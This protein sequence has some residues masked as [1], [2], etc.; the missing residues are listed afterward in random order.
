MK[1]IDQKINILPI[2]DTVSGAKAR[3]DPNATI[4]HYK[5]L[6]KQL[7]LPPKV[8]NIADD[9]LNRV[10][11]GNTTWGSISGPY[12]FGKTANAI[13][14]WEYARRQ[15]YVVIPPLTC[16]S[17]DELAYGIAALTEV[18]VPKAKKQVRTLFK[19]IWKEELKQI[20]QKD[21]QRY[22]ISVEKITRI[23]EDKLSDGHLTIDGHCH[24]LVEFLSKLGE[25][26]LDYSKGLIII[27]D[28][29]QQLLGPLDVRSIV[30]F[31]E[32]VWG[33]RTERSHCG[34]VLVFDSLL[35]A[36]LERWA[37][38]VL[39][40]IRENGPSLQLSSVYSQ[41]FPFWLWEK[42]IK[43][44][45][46]QINPLSITGD[47]LKSLG[48]FVERSDI[49][50]GPRTVVDVFSRAIGFYAET[51][52]S[53]DIPKFVQDINT[54]QFRYFGE[55]ALIQR[56]LNQL[57]S[58]E[59][60][61][62][63]ETRK[64]LVTTL[65][66]YPL[67]CPQTIISR[68]IPDNT[69]FQRARSDLFGALLVE[70]SNG[71]ALEQFQHVRRPSANWE[72][73]LSRCWETLP[74]FDAL[75]AHLPDI[76]SRIL[77]SRIFPKGNPNNPTWERISDDSRYLLNG[78]QIYRGSFDDSYPSREVA[79]SVSYSG[80][81]TWLND[82]DICI[83]F[84]CNSEIQEPSAQLIEGRRNCIVLNMPILKS[85][86]QYV[87]AELERYKKFIQPE[88]FRPASILTAMHEIEIF[89][90]A[91][92]GQSNEIAR[93]TENE[94]WVRR[95][96]ALMEISLDFVVREM[97]QGTVDV[98][99]N[100]LLNL[101]GIELIRALFTKSCREQF[102]EYITLIKSFKWKES[103]ERY[104]NALKN[105]I[106]NKAQRQGKQAIIMPKSEL[107]ET[108]FEQASTAAGD[109]FIRALGP[110]IKTSGDPQ[111]FAVRLELHP[112][113]VA[114]LRF[115]RG[116]KN[117]ESFPQDVAIQY[118]KH[119]GYIEDETME[120][121]NLLA[122]RELIYYK[123][124]RE[125]QVIKDDNA[126]RDIHV[127]K[128][129]ELEKYLNLLGL[130]PEEIDVNDASIHKL[131]QYINNLE[132]LIA[133]QLEFQ[134]NELSKTIDSLN[135]LI[136]K[137]VASKMHREW[138][139]SRISPHLTGI[140]SALE[141]T[142]ENL[143]KTLRQELKKTENEL[144]ILNNNGLISFVDQR[145]KSAFNSN[146]WNKL[147]EQVRRF[148]DRV[149][150][151]SNWIPID[152]QLVSVTSL[153]HKISATDPGPSQSLEML[154]DEYREQFAT[155]AWTPLYSYGDFS[156]RL[157]TIQAEVQEL[158][159]R[160]FQ[161][162]NSELQY[163]NKGFKQLLPTLPSPQFEI[164]NE[165]KLK[166]I[167][168]SFQSLY[169]WVIDGFR[170]SVIKCHSMREN[171]ESWRNCSGGSISWNELNNQISELLENSVSNLNFEIVCNIGA[172]VAKLVDGFCIS[173]KQ[174][175]DATT[176]SNKVYDDP[177]DPPNFKELEELFNKGSILIKI[178]PNN[179]HC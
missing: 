82:V 123:N 43:N 115:L 19:E 30:R 14:L 24:R 11:Q 31:R 4:E 32:F 132:N 144:T 66:A 98:G 167:Q 174:N 59:W 85:L 166:S 75:V 170:N 56:I 157:K 13:A 69:K 135:G 44:Y 142:K 65:A 164:D 179:R 121:I 35:E 92:L 140:S 172:K 151:L 136:G 102:P 84:V 51:G 50:N 159:Y 27:L 1:I 81:K 72:Q 67:G 106:L 116:L 3:Q 134:T 120:I 63:D 99:D 108:L 57:L 112:A 58:D 150:A 141:Q 86:E 68:F 163:F 162:F 16:T 60:I 147:N 168:D 114:L 73:M 94:V 148:V 161:A 87:P 41:D 22:T 118:L 80:P 47:V 52:M 21:A 96:Q 40:R 145:K 113:E 77:F 129:M 39:H 53:Y 130:V 79:V 137:V 139:V 178:E 17:F 54:G 100:R 33:M 107:F 153:C 18:L 37:A 89:L 5:F 95:A 15:G 74:G 155:I 46:S 117:E 70:L 29:L 76:I 93:Q 9:I 175:M 122:D 28:E 138:S 133:T 7:W 103:L 126:I 111:L 91:I 48:Q 36:R 64:I 124:E 104:R 169:R 154:V 42:I 146:S 97:L 125:V 83:A 156:V 55:N 101:R 110:L 152:S 158:L 177:L 131:Q 61:I 26:V 2:A 10:S 105:D 49:A 119:K 149:S 90:G 38:D 88:P 62:E 20:A 143:L 45:S 171:G 160:H 25:L 128:I 78:W 34:V 173:K 165:D 8:K 127:G 71:L 109:S 23:L 6:S 176:L 12:G